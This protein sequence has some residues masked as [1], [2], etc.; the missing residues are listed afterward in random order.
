MPAWGWG[1]VVVAA[2]VI[3]AVVMWRALVARRTR[4]L[5]EGFGP[6]YDRTRT[7]VGDKRKA[8]AELAAR[9]ERREHLDI[10]PLP[11]EAR[12]RYARQ[13]DAVQTQFVDSP[14]AAIAAADGLVNAVMADRGYPI[15]DFEQR[16]GDVSV[17]HPAVVENYR[18]AHAISL[19]STRGEATTEDLRQAMQNYRSLFEELLSDSAADAPLARDPES[20]AYT[21]QQAASTDNEP[22]AATGR[23]VQ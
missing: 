22:V 14:P 5:R 20:D 12:K 15:H 17:D 6:E 4:S 23:E 18:R 8:E 21:E 2:V 7:A 10:R 19:R 11:A 1:I 9:R 3:V 16:A 13:W